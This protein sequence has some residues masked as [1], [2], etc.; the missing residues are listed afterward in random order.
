MAAARTRP[1]D[2]VAKD[3]VAEDQ[4]AE[5]V[6]NDP[7]AQHETA[8]HGTAEHETAEDAPVPA[9]DE[10]GAGDAA[11][12]ARGGRGRRWRPAGGSDPL[13]AVALV[14]AVIAASCAGWFG[15]SWYRAAYDDSLRYSQSRDEV[16]RAGEQAVQNLNTLDYRDVD[17]GL[18]TWQESSAGELHQQITQG[19]EQFEQQVRQAKTISTA[20]VLEGAVTELDDRAGKAGIII[21]VQITVTPPTGAPTTK[22]SRLLGQLTRTSTGWKLTA[23]GQAPIGGAASDPGP[24]EGPADEPADGPGNE[25]KTG[26]T[27]RS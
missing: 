11:R 17:R 21:A 25:P 13:F 19:R 2:E 3:Q 20:R 23:L 26:P 18:N 16:L 12:A 8:E 24:A 22:Q 10:D 6:T 27:P 15:L 14:T 4:V 7:V 1:G 9:A 5:E